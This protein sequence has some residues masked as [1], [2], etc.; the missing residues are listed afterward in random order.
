MVG[1][2]FAAFAWFPEFL[3]ELIG[4]LDLPHRDGPVERALRLG[5]RRPPAEAGPSAD[6]GPS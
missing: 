6:S 3:K 4:V 1:I 5:R 2:A